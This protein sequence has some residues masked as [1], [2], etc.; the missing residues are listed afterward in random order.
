MSKKI[1]LELDT[2]QNREMR[3]GSII[4]WDGSASELVEESDYS[5]RS[6]A[7]KCGKSCR[8]CELSVPFQQSSMCS[9]QIAT[10][11]AGNLTDCILIHH[12]PIGCSGRSPIYEQTFRRG[13]KRKGID[14]FSVRIIST[15][16]LEKDMVFGAAEKLRRTAREAFERYSPKAVF[17]N[18][19]CTTAI[20]GEDLTSIAEELEDELGVPVIPLHCEGFRS[21]H[22]STGFD[23]VQHGVVRQIAN[24]NPQ[25]QNDLINIIALWGTDYFTDMLKPLG[26]RVNYIMEI[27]SFAELQQI[28]EAAA[29]TTFCHTLGSYMATALEEKFGVPQIKASQPYGIKGT[30]EWLRAIAKTVGKEAKAEEYIKA[31]HERIK[32]ELEKLRS[33]LKGK[34]G[35]VLTGSAYAHGLISVLRELG[36]EVPGS[37]V[38][39]HDPV[40][41]SGSEEQDTLKNLVNNYG[42]IPHFT[43]SK[44]QPFQT[45]QLFRRTPV[46][47]VIV[48]HGGIAPDL[49]KQGIVSFVM[50]DE[51]LPLGYD[52]ILRLGKAILATLP[53]RRFNQVLKR[54]VSSVYTDWWLS[55]DDPFLLSNHPEVL[56]EENKNDEYKAIG[57]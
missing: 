38:F 33:L 5:K 41:D 36:M 6:C 16:L 46:D 26:L 15:N 17:I 19:S 4:A 47:I 8:L 43:V 13:L 23:I 9:Q 51:H 12:S 48:R 30:D 35:Y 55:Q 22:W 45:P 49:A 44:T 37:L 32:P 3:L 20:I 54:H 1:N 39:H 42:D 11:Q 56:K 57:A 7:G 25:K 34:T 10:C 29:T 14:P 21:K 18:M 27:A 24:K 2:P 53:R 28:S 31:E 40:Y 52:G 50:G